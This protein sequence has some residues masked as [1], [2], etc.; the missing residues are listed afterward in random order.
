MSQG[1]LSRA[2]ISRELRYLT[3]YLKETIRLPLVPSCSSGDLMRGRTGR[4]V[5][6]Q[7]EEHPEY[8]SV[9]GSGERRPIERPVPEIL[10]LTS[11]IVELG[12]G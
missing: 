9:V 3:C 7:G 11:S 2:G 4:L 12:T 6:R 10:S 1:R 8:P 5:P